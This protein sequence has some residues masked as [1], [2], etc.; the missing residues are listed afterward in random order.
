[1]ALF[2][3]GRSRALT[4]GIE[5]IALIRE[6]EPFG[7]PGRRNNSGDSIFDLELNRFGTRKYRF[8][9]EVRTPDRDPYEIEGRF[10]VP[11]KAENTGF[12]AADVGNALRPGI[13]LP[14][15]VDPSGAAS[16]EVD[17]KKFLAMPGRKEAQRAATQSARN[18]RVREQLEKSPKLAAK[19]RA[20]NSQAV[21]MWADAVRGGNMT[22]EEFEETVNLELETGRM[23]PADAEAA[24]R[25]LD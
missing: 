4:G 21:Q 14:V 15:R 17:W 5:G 8:V 2:G 11:R 9:L 13:E 1:M 12:L 24:R 3:L 6:S 20:N 10:K 25:T 16:V 7:E 23:D 18:V 19:L 22:R